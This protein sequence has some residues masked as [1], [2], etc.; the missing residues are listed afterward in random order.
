MSLNI[1]V[2]LEEPDDSIIPIW[3]DELN[4]LGMDCKIHP[5][6]SFNDHTGFLPF[7]IKVNS[8]SHEDLMHKE[9]LTGFEFYMDDFV[10][11]DNVEPPKN[12]SLIDK[13]LNKPIETSYFVSP[14]IDEKLMS[15]NKVITFNWG[16]SDT[17]ELRMA[18]LASATLTK[19][20][21]GVCCYPADNIWYNTETV[22]ENSLKEVSDYEKSLKPSEF[23][24][25][26]FEKWI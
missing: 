26:K 17:F 9:Y 5:D 11:S 8:N 6:F 14:E 21:N 20:A 3:I 13:L 15:F 22:V 23:K 24:L 10:L 19:I 4:K 1:N 7:K 25:H 2:F 12:R 16:S 18:L